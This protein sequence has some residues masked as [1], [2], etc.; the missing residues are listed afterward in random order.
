[1]AG[2]LNN[3]EV[4]LGVGDATAYVQTCLI[5]LLYKPIILDD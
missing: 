4:L 1:L 3:I 2:T 5:N